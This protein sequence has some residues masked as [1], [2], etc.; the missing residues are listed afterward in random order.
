MVFFQKNKKATITVLQVLLMGAISILI[1]FAVIQLIKGPAEDTAAEAICK[2]SV[3]A[4]AKTYKELTVKGVTVTAAGSPILCR[5]LNKYIPENKDATKQDIEKEIAGL[6]AQC[7]NRYYEG[8]IPDV[9]KAGD[10]ANENCQ[11]CYTLNIRETPTFK[12]SKGTISNAD[13]QQYLFSNPYKAYENGDF[14][15]VQLD[16]PGGFCS[17]AEK[18]T[19]CV[20]K[21]AAD[22]SYILIDKKND[23]CMQKNK[24][25]CCYTDYE[26][27]NKG[28][29]CS[30]ENP[31]STQIAFSLY[32]NW[33]CPSKM[34]CYIKKE[35][36]F[37]YGDYIRKYGGPGNLLMFT[38]EIKP[39]E[40][41]AISFGSPTDTCAWCDAASKG[42][43]Q[44]V[45]IGTGATILYALS[46]GGAV[47]TVVSF[48]PGGIFVVAGGA[49]LAAGGVAYFGAEATTQ[50]TH[51]QIDDIF[52]ERKINTIYFSTLNDMTQGKHCSL[53]KDIREK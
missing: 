44:G 19:D 46:Q 15:S 10:S 45:A 24:K 2:F 40:T 21:I 3:G 8:R 4:R 30:A 11:I 39:G 12:G 50:F 13:M 51:K 1:I 49:A 26:C 47:A 22:P 32:D 41:Y 37:S 18:N 17:D 27:W 38:P 7:W 29:I 16:A 36:Y 6:M 53:V 9:F 48:I 20:S 33:K 42:V 52:S 28:G 43:G 35:D 23:I 14:C 25:S 31:D 34:H 5:T